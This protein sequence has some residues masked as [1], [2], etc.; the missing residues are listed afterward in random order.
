MQRLSTRI[1]LEAVS[2]NVI[3]VVLW[4]LGIP[5]GGA[6]YEQ[7]Y[8]T[9]FKNPLKLISILAVIIQFLA[10]IYFIILTLR[11]SFLSGI[12]ESINSSQRL[13]FI[14]RAQGFPVSFMLGV[15]T[16]LAIDALIIIVKNIVH[17]NL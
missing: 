6:G 8:P 3:V 1:F 4:I 2:A 7:I 13:P 16:G 10:S 5:L 9:I 12:I 14:K 17:L 15:F 11:K